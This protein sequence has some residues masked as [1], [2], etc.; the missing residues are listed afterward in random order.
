MKKLITIL[1]ASLLLSAAVRGQAMP[2]NEQ[3]NSYQ[4]ME[5]ADLD[6]QTG[7]EENAAE[8]YSMADKQYRQG[9][10]KAAKAGQALE[11]PPDC[12][13]CTPNPGGDVQDVPFDKNLLFIL[14]AGALLI[15]NKVYGAD[16]LNED[17]AD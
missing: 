12:P 10:A 3:A 6:V 11:A 8:V 1:Y 5:A 2:M 15:F 13:E 9:T 7:G 14:F 17:V 16:K 4:Q